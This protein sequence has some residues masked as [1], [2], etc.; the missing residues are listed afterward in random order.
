M[1]QQLPVNGF[2]RA[3]NLF[4]FNRTFIKNYNEKINEG[5]FLQVD[6]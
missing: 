4:E 5:H 3:K 1:S 2:K 6:F